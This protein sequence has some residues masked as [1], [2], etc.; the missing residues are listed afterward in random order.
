[1]IIQSLQLSNGGPVLQKMLAGQTD[2]RRKEI[3]KAISKA[4]EKYADNITGKVK[5]GNEAILIVG[6]K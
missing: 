1:M 2:E 3:L 4:A 5:F 6:R